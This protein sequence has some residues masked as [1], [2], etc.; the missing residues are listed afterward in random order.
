MEKASQA[1][2]KLRLKPQ[3]DHGNQRIGAY[4]LY[5]KINVGKFECG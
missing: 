5:Y 1:H 2:N 3:H 4:F